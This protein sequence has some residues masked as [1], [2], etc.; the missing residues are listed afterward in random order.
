MCRESKDSYI[1]LSSPDSNLSNFIE[2][3]FTDELRIMDQQ[4][5]IYISYLFVEDGGSEAALCRVSPFSISRTPL[6]HYPFSGTS[7]ICWTSPHVVMFWPLIVYD[8]FVRHR[9]KR[10]QKI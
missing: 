9:G 1:F 5:I 7:L 10:L 6:F 3:K 2:R 8:S 4:L